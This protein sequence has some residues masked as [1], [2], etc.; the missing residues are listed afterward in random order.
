M[1]IGITA[2]LTVI[3]TFIFL[4]IQ[5]SER[6]KRIIVFVAFLVVGELIR[7]YTFYRNVHAEAW[8]AL[9]LALILN[10]AFWLF[11]GRYNPVKSSDEIQVIGLDD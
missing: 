6:K 8:V 2:L 11:F 1:D 9:I 5:R 4:L 7:R 10:F 3:F